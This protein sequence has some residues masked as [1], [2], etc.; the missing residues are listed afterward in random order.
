MNRLD[1][2]HYLPVFLKPVPGRI[3]VF[4]PVFHSAWIENSAFL[5]QLKLKPLV[6]PYLN[7]SYFSELN[8]PISF[9]DDATNYE[10]TLLSL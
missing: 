7:N 3:I 9:S 8:K 2:L 5:N 1:Q 4:N 10:K 6:T